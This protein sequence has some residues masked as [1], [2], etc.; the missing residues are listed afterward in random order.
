MATLET[1]KGVSVGKS[2]GNSFGNCQPVF[3]F[4]GRTGVSSIRVF[5]F[6]VFATLWEPLIKVVLAGSRLG[7]SG[8]FHERGFTKQVLI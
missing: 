5:L 3:S 4:L 7:T 8:V 1:M 6:F 2:I